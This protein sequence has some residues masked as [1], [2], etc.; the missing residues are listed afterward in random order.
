MRNAFFVAVGLAAACAPAER[1][2]ATPAAPDTAAVRQAIQAH[3]DRWAEF[4]IAANAA[5][6]AGL[7]A[8]DATAAFFGL[9]TATGS[10]A[11][12]ALFNAYFSTTRVTAAASAVTTVAAP[13]PGVATALGTYTVTTDSSGVV[14][15]GWYRWAA[16]YRQGADGQW[17]VG[18]I[19][20]FPDSVVRK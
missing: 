4:D 15:T 6:L 17:R 7:H 12:E 1:E 3:G 5:G 14:R 16:A 13:A 11:I 10:A 2:V 19:Q 9:P 18:Y 8:E 20:S